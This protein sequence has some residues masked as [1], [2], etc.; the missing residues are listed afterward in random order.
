MD[1]YSIADIAMPRTPSPRMKE[2]K[3][4]IPESLLRDMQAAASADGWKDAEFWR[5]CLTIGFHAY[6]SGSNSVLVNKKLRN[7]LAERGVEDA[8]ET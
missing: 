4:S 8:P 7:F 3:T 5:L 2:I 1:E 6:S